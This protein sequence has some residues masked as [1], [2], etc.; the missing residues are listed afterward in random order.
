[1]K[2][3]YYI[4]M[5]ILLILSS[6]S[7]MKN[8]STPVCHISG[9]VSISTTADHG[10]DWRG[11]RP[12]P[13]GIRVYLVNSKASEVID[14]TMTDSI[15]KYEFEVT[16]GDYHLL[17]HRFKC[18]ECF[19]IHSIFQVV[20]PPLQFN[21]QVVDSIN[22]FRKVTATKRVKTAVDLSIAVTQH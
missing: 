19:G 8:T 3:E 11:P 6:C 15:G 1:M 16:E 21:S 7:T 22:L 13:N 18:A 4:F 12:S 17:I 14:S 2:I 9:I 5:A 20:A 10:G